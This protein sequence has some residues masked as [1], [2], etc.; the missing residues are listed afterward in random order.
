[1]HCTAPSPSFG[2]LF[3]NLLSLGRAS[4][5]NASSGRALVGATHK[6]PQ[7]RLL[8]TTVAVERTIELLDSAGLLHAHRQSASDGQ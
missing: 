4:V 7:H 3:P 2:T 8:S 1:M 5:D 6:L